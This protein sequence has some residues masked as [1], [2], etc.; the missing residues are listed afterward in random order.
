MSVGSARAA[1]TPPAPGAAAAGRGKNPEIARHRFSPT[2]T[3]ALHRDEDLSGRA[4][5]D[6]LSGRDGRVDDRGGRGSGAIPRVTMLSFDWRGLRYLRRHHPAV[7][8]GWL[9]QR[10]MSEAERRSWWGEGG[11][12][13]SSLSA[14]Q[15]VVDEGA[16]CW[17]PEFRS[18][19]RTM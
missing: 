6:G 3:P 2:R 13:G 5:A 1:P 10:K 19:P 16:P 11:C 15:A 9:T 7:A 8:T 14:L 18:C 17:L 4:G 12:L